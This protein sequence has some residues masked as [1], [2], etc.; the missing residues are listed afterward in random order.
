VQKEPA[1]R[2]LTLNSRPL[3][4]PH[5]VDSWFVATVSATT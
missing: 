1:V 5:E 4:V 2:F 3:P